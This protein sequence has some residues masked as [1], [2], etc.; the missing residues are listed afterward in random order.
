MCTLVSKH[1][2]WLSQHSI[3][4]TRDVATAAV[5]LTSQVFCDVMLCRQ[6]CFRTFQRNVLPSKVQDLSTLEGK[7]TNSA[8]TSGCT[9]GHVASGQ[10]LRAA[11]SGDGRDRSDELSDEIRTP[12]IRIC[13]INMAAGFVDVL[14]NVRPA[15]K[16]KMTQSKHKIWTLLF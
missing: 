15:L 6:I 9:K 7:C 16:K 11:H 4:K 13:R 10:N 5:C 12:H 2:L 8:Q 3:N 14:P 1:V